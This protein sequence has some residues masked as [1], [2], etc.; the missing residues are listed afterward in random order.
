MIPVDLAC[1]GVYFENP[2]NTLFVTQLD[3]VN[4][5]AVYVLELR[6]DDTGIGVFAQRFGIELF[7]RLKR[8]CITEAQ[9]FL[10][11]DAARLNETGRKNKCKGRQQGS[12]RFHRGI[13]SGQCFYG[14]HLNR[15]N[16]TQTE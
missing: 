11:V 4:V 3:I 8:T 16:L 1:G 2:L 5:P 7:S 13:H 9:H 15:D 12:Q 6:A 10:R 14:D